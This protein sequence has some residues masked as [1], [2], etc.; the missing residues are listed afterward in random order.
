[1]RQEGFCTP[2]ALEIA[3]EVQNPSFGKSLDP[4]GAHCPIHL[5]SRH[6][7]VSFGFIFVTFKIEMR[8][9]GFLRI[10]YQG[11]DDNVCVV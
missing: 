10:L 9:L 4:R 2:S 3:L 5:S 11:K 7:I 6:C 8:R 1:M